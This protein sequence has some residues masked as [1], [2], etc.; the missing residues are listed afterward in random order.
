MYVWLHTASPPQHIAM[1]SE[2]DL[3]NTGGIRMYLQTI[4][5]RRGISAK[6]AGVFEAP[7]GETSVHIFD[8]VERA[9]AWCE[10]N[11]DQDVLIST[12]D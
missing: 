3:K 4:N 12:E 6:Y 2:P 11:S 8:T 5:I 1:L 10:R 9:T 7:N